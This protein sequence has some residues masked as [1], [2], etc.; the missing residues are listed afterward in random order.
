MNSRGR[1]ALR[2][3]HGNGSHCDPTLKGSNNL[4][5]L[6]LSGSGIFLSILPVGVAQSR[7]PTAIQFGPFGTRILLGKQEV[8]HLL[9]RL[10]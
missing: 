6:T 1:A 4:E 3:A 5:R 2:D 8:D 9:R 10:F 7:S